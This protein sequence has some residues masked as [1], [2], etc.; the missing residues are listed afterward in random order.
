MTEYYTRNPYKRPESGDVYH[1][2][3]QA[4]RVTGTLTPCFDSG[5]ILL[6]TVKE[7]ADGGY[8][9]KYWSWKYAKFM[10]WFRNIKIVKAGE[11]YYWRDP[12]TTPER[13]DIFRLGY[14]KIEVLFAD[15]GDMDRVVIARRGSSTDDIPVKHEVLT[16]M[17]ANTGAYRSEELT[18]SAFQKLI[19]HWTHVAVE[20]TQGEM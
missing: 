8:E 19:Q 5:K 16:K 13:G 7:D 11:F 18:V 12:W 17:L 4:W 3:K 20:Y 14:D 15:V 6:T 2:G 1:W 10:F 9:S